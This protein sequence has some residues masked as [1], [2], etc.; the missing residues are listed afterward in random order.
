LIEPFYDIDWLKKQRRRTGD[1]NF[2]ASIQNYLEDTI[3]DYL[4]IAYEKYPI[5]N[6]CLSG[7]VAANIIMSLN[8]YER[9]NFKNIYVLPPMADDGLAIGSA[10]LTAIVLDQDDSWLIDC[11]MPY[12][13]D[14][15]TRIQ[16][17]ETLDSFNNI[18][19]EDLKDNWPQEAA[20]SV[21]KGKICA[22]FQGKM[23]F[24]PR[25]L[26]NRSIIANPMLED[27]RQKI[28]S[29]VKRRPHYQ[30][31]CPSILE[32]ERE[33]L[34]RSS[35]SHKHMAIAFRMKDEFIKDLPCAVHVDGTARPQFVEEKDNPNYYRYLTALKD[36]TG[37]GVSLN[38]S[39]NLHGRTIVRTPEDAVVDFIDCNIDELFI[40]GYR[41]KR[42]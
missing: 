34:F 17:K 39:F 25:A 30:P 13:G 33:R 10:I 37:Y 23:E 42:K 35:F 5:N 6:L 21:S 11:V 41:V 4:N 29:T 9:T 32:E 3:V 24:G 26:G 1:E 31:F 2:C 15:Y 20:I 28:N 22:L 19:Y 12:F 18:I 38:T 36:I 7:G 40:E 14:S 8:I 27:T 16:V